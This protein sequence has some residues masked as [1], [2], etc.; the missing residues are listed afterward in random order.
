ML[1]HHTGAIK[2]GGYVG[3]GGGVAGWSFINP[4][5]EMESSSMTA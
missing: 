5:M 4:L 3:R 2:T 1:Y